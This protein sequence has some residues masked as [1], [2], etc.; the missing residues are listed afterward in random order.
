MRDTTSFVFIRNCCLR[1]GSGDDSRRLGG[2]DDS[3]SSHLNGGETLGLGLRACGDVT[4]PLRTDMRATRVSMQT[5]FHRQEWL[6]SLKGEEDT[7]YAWD[8]S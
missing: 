7:L 2:R 5:T 6:H 4:I 3:P 8:T 1:G